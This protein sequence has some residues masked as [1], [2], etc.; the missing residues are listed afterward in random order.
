MWGDNRFGQLGD[1]T[2]ISR[3][4]P[5]SISVGSTTVAS[6]SLGAYHTG[7]ITTGIHNFYRF[8]QLKSIQKTHC[9]P[10]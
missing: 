2:T 5:V 4:S 3:K 1:G 8:K 10:I 6:V 7:A 9:I